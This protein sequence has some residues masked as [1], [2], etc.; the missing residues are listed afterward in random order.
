MFAA[1]KHHRQVRVQ[2]NDDPDWRLLVGEL[3]LYFG[4][5]RA[6]FRG[7]RYMS[8]FSTLAALGL[9]VRVHARTRHS[10]S[11]RCEF[12]DL[13]HVIRGAKDIEHRGR[14]NFE[15]SRASREGEDGAE[16]VFVLRGL[17]C[18][19]GVMARVVRPRCDF[20]YENLT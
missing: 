20:V 16:V 7:W 5:L 9:A 6:R 15:S 12:R 3:R 10:K 1:G 19:G 18:F 8:H 13:R 4:H 2:A 17:A 14:G 11:E